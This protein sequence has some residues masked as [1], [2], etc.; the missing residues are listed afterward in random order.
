M[1]RIN[2]C[3]FNKDDILYY[4]HSFLG[5]QYYIEFYFKNKTVL[6]FNFQNIE[7][8]KEKISKIDEVFKVK[9]I[10]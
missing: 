1:I 3:R 10:C 4:N 9:T 7:I 8:A 2:D 6:K 5:G